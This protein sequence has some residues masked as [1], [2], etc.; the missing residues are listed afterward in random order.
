MKRQDV[1]EIVQKYFVEQVLNEQDTGLDASTP[2]LEWGLVN[3]IEIIRLLTFI[4]ERFSIEIPASEMTASNFVTIG[5]VADMILNNASS[6][7][8]TNPTNTSL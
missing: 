4:Q 8:V 7:P 5:A 1:I 2:L 3:S 6:A